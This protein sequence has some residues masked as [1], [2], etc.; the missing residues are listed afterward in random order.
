MFGR[1]IHKLRKKIWL[2]QGLSFDTKTNKYILKKYHFLSKIDW[3]LSR[4]QW[5]FK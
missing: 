4:L 5:I 2:I 3:F 1:Q